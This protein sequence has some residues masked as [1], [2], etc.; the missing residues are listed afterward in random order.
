M[1]SVTK[2]EIPNY[3][4]SKNQTVTWIFVSYPLTRCTIQELVCLS[5]NMQSQKCWRQRNSV[6]INVIK[7]SRA[8]QSYRWGQWFRKIKHHLPFL[9]F[10]C[11]GGFYLKT[12][13][14]S[15]INF[16]FCTYFQAKYL[17]WSGWSIFERRARPNRIFGF[18]KQK[19]EHLGSISVW[20]QW[21]KM[22]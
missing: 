14:N 20:Q 19:F 11:V 2:F 10:G 8:S 15:V 7:K 22:I 6:N 17:K 3:M 18:L 4:V 13:I 5:R 12:I 1:L 21:A 9:I 16:Y